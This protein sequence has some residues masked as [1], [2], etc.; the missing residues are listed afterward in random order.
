MAGDN[1]KNVKQCNNKLNDISWAVLAL[2]TD[3]ADMRER[4]GRIVIGLS[5]SGDAVTADDLGSFVLS[6]LKKSRFFITFI[7]QAAAAR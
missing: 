4:L 3:V 2:A 7:R 6:F 1:R 5:R